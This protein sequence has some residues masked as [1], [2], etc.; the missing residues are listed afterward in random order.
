MAAWPYP[1][2]RGA[3][4]EP[5]T[6]AS[7][8]FPAGDHAGSRFTGPGIWPGKPVHPPVTA[9]KTIGL[10]FHKI[11]SLPASVATSRSDGAVAR[12][13]GRTRVGARLT[14]RVPDSG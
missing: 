12:N 7:V 9:H 14:G 13:D 5:C 2:G 4:T 1:G 10:P 8:G 11:R 6:K 3:D